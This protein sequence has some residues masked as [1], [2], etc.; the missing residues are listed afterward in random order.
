MHKN[1]VLNEEVLNKI[2]TLEFDILVSEPKFSEEPKKFSEEPG[3]ES[4]LKEFGY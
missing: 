4:I 3:L 2:S 1:C